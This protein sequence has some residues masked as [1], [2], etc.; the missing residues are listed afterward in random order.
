MTLPSDPLQLSDLPE[1]ILVVGGYGYRNTG[2]E[3][4][5]AGLLNT[6]AGRRVT[7]VSR[8]PA[9]TSALHGV[10]AVG[11]SG[12]VAALRRHR[13][14][15]IGGG[16]LF[17]RDVGR[18]GRM[19]PLFGLL[20]AGVGRTLVVDGVG[21]DPGVSGISQL[22]LRRVLTR[23][24]GVTVRD[25]ASSRLLREWGIACSVA[26]DLSARMPAAPA[27]IG[28]DLLRA[29][30]VDPKRPAIGLCLT[31]V[32]QSLTPSVA[33][34]IL[35]L[36]DRQPDLQFCLVPLSQHPYVTSHNDLVLAR[37]LQ[38]SCPKLKI[39]EGMVHPSRVLSIFGA[40][41]AVVAMRY[42]AFL[43]AERA[44]TPL[45]PIAYAPKNIAWLD[46]RGLRPVAPTGRAL[47]RAL[48]RALATPS[49][50]LSAAS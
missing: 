30:G 9:E 45:V 43:F 41:D 1:P 32:N 48:R 25:S 16:G 27:R 28:R 12:A 21:I 47:R 50:A 31:A 18:I 23:A 6:L 11:L 26:D 39:V 20:A 2:D 14:V 49:P 19:L 5:L 4:I 36:I 44:G 7:V 37:A 22:T 34:A 46:E 10:P 15:L 17:G 29:A 40:L 3:A 42:H 8:A 33:A 38:S 13:S 24:Q 35:D